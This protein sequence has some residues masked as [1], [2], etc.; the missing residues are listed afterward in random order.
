MVEQGLFQLLASQSSVTS[1]IGSDVKN[2]PQI[3]WVLTPKGVNASDGFVVIQ[4]FNTSDLVTYDGYTGVRNARFQ[5]DCYSAALNGFYNSRAIA[6]AVRNVLAGYKGTLPDTDSTEVLAVFIENDR[7]MQYEE[8][9][10]AFI[11]RAMLDVCVWYL[12]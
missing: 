8:G 12:D 7:D 3:Y 9:G 1:L 11:Y 2:N 4:R 6:T 10:S 5:V